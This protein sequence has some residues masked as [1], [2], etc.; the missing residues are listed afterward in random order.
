MLDAI[1]KGA[2]ENIKGSTDSEHLAALYITFLTSK[3]K[4]QGRESWELDYPVAEMAAA[5]ASAINAIIE[6]QQ[7]I[8]GVA[9]AQA[10]SL[11]VGVTGVLSRPGVQRT[12]L[13]NDRIDGSQMVAC[14]YRNH[15][16]EQ[17]PSLYWS[18]TAGR[19]K[20]VRLAN[21]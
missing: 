12:E 3:S 5:L 1:E 10:N 4:V 14:R 19:K 13:T 15:A 7:K 8:L 16:V 6:L 9:V 18:G 2:Y 20:R 11:N 17:P 21:H